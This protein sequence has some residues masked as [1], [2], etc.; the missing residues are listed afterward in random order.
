MA[1][2]TVSGK[3]I[4]AE[5]QQPLTGA[6]V[7][8]KSTNKKTTTDATGFFK[9]EATETDI[10]IISN[11]GYI[12][13]KVKTS[14]AAMVF[15]LT[16]TKNLSD[17]VVTALGVKR[18]AKR[19]GYAVQEIKGSD[20]VKAREPNPINSLVGKISGLD[21]AISREMLAAP[22][23]SLRGGNISLYVVD[24]MPITSDTWNIS[25]MTLKPILY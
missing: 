12:E 17:V 1:Q 20:L 23:V 24:G 11:V 7:T 21:V 19:L 18:D 25:L 14:D 8:V 13:Q 4:S 3:V 6:T 22:A 9:I 10:L 5:N 15:L 16:D 2:R